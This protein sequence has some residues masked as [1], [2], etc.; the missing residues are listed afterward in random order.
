[1]RYLAA[2]LLVFET[3]QLSN[4]QSK[5]VTVS[6]RPVATS[7]FDWI[8]INETGTKILGDVPFD[9]L[10]A[11]EKNVWEA[12][13]GTT[14]GVRSTKTVDIPVNIHG[15]TKVYTLMNTLWEFPVQLQYRL[16]SYAQMA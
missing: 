1:M 6:L 8:P 15:P 16:A 3:V 13:F 12:G 10:P 9:L 5:F 4:A 7:K 14:L 2:L 11:S